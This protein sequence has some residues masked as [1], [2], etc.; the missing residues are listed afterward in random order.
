MISEYKNVFYTFNLN[1]IGGVETF[2]FELARKYGK[3]DITVFYQ[4]GD[5]NQIRRLKKYVKVRK[6]NGEKIKC[7]KMFFN[8]DIDIIDN[9]E[10][11][12]YVM[13]IHAMFKSQKDI[14]AITH[15]KIT[16]YLCV[17]ESAGKEF[18]ELTGIKPEL[19]RNPLQMSKEE[20]KPVI[21]LIS[22]TRLTYEKGK[23]RMIKLAND[24]DNAGIN[25]I[26]LIF[27]NDTDVIDNPNI[28]YMKPRLNI[29]PYIASIKGKG[30]G[31]QLSDAEGDCFFTRE[32][33]ELGVPLIVTPIPSFKEQGLKENINCYYMPFDMV[34]T[35]V[36]RLLNI[37]EYEPYSIA[38]QWDK[39]LF[40]SKS[41]YI[42]DKEDF[43]ED[44]E[45]Q[46]QFN[47]NKYARM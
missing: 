47:F 35:K 18:E 12:E 10:A 43:S 31:C 33:E 44:D 38:D 11:K 14:V 45:V 24:L 19:C 41:T 9:I 46:E 22:A 26:W 7:E 8:Y 1:I 5:L 36:E 42:E 27:T 3:Y 21:W 2:L 15:P 23:H 40:H 6:Y 16:K 20:K 29:R 17:S 30:F 39:Y 25:Y 34:D 32:C 4:T 37:L 13:I 28:V